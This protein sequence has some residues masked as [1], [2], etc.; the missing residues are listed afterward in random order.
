MLARPLVAVVV[1]LTAGAG[2]LVVAGGTSAADGPVVLR[3]AAAPRV[4]YGPVAVPSRSLPGALPVVLPG[5]LSGAGA[6]S[7]TRL[8][9]ATPVAPG[10]PVGPATGSPAMGPPGVIGPDSPLRQVRAVQRLL[11]RVGAALRVDGAWGPATTR[12]VIA[13]QAR[14]GLPVDGRVGPRTLAVLRAQS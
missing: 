1:L 7:L 5:A 13:V 12:A 2:S 11:N 6:P 10:P 3:H 9:P 14:T 4:V 8:L